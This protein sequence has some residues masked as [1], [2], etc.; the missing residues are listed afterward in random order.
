MI[1]A[2]SYK[3]KYKYLHLVSELTVVIIIINMQSLY[4]PRHSHNCFSPGTKKHTGVLSSMHTTSRLLNT[5]AHVFLT[6][7][8]CDLNSS[9][10]DP[11]PT[12]SLLS[13]VCVYNGLLKTRVVCFSSVQCCS[14]VFGV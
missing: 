13:T 10:N 5:A 4:Y 9:S 2:Y 7:L 12:K 6:F 11:H 8:K 14:L 3:N 1:E